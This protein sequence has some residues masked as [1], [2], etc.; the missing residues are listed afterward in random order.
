M[1]DDPKV[2]Q[3]TQADVEPQP[4]DTENDV[5][6]MQ[7][8]P[9]IPAPFQPES[10]QAGLGASWTRLARHA[11]YFYRENAEENGELLHSH[12]FK[13]DEPACLRPTV[14]L[15]HVTKLGITNLR[16]LI[17]FVAPVQPWVAAEDSL[18]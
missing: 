7:P 12:L 4:V 10:T 13:R 3:N 15:R 2:K 5:S 9:Q 11:S 8:D 18:N 6:D 17:A 14:F 16:L 1:R